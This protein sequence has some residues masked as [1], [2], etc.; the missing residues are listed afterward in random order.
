MSLTQSRKR[1][2][3]RIL[4]QLLN[5]CYRLRSTTSLINYL[6]KFFRFRAHLFGLFP[7]PKNP[8]QRGGQFCC[9]HA[10]RRFAAAI[11]SYAKVLDAVCEIK[12]VEPARQNDLWNPSTARF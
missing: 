3:T 4:Q 6:P 9:L 8:H 11:D 10:R 7:I 1:S 2:R 5:L 12:G